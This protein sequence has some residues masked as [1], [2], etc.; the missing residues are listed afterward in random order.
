MMAHNLQENPE[1]VH[2]QVKVEPFHP[3]TVRYFSS[4]GGRRS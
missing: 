3:E 2:A 4:I 1:D